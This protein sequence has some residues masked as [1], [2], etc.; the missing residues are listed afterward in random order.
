[1]PN[2]EY[3]ESRGTAVGDKN[4]VES[5]VRKEVKECCQRLASFKRITRLLIQHEELEKT[6]TKK[7]K[8]YLYTGN[9]RRD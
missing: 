1:V 5:I 9:L 4:L 8:R 2:V 7:I 6:T 3:L